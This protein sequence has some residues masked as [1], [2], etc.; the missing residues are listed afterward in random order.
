MMRRLFML[1]LFAYSATLFSGK[2]EKIYL[3]AEI[4]FDYVLVASKMDDE[5]K[6]KAALARFAFIQSVSME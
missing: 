5:A 6:V 4:E 3:T 2:V 1:V